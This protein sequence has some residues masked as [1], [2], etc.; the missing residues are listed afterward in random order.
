[1]S[2]QKEITFNQ[3]KNEKNGKGFSTALLFNMSPLQNSLFETEGVENPKLNTSAS[4]AQGDTSSMMNDFLTSDL[5]QKIDQLSPITSTRQP[6]SRMSDVEMVNC[7]EENDSPSSEL[8]ESSS[9]ELE[10]KEEFPIEKK[11]KKKKNAKVTFGVS[12]MEKEDKKSE[13]KKLN[14]SYTAREA[15]KENFIENK[16]NNSTIN[17]HNKSFSNANNTSRIF[18][19]YENTSKYLSQALAEEEKN[20]KKLFDSLNNSH[21]YIPKSK[22]DNKDIFK[23][24]YNLAK[25]EQL[26]NEDNQFD[27]SATKFFGALK[28]T[29]TS[30]YSFN[31]FNISNDSSVPTTPQIPT[32]KEQDQQPQFEY[33]NQY[34]NSNNNFNM[35]NQQQNMQNKNYYDFVNQYQMLQQQ[36]QIPN[37]NP[38]EMNNNYFDYMTMLMNNNNPQFNIPS[39]QLPQTQIESSIFPQSNSNKKNKK[40][41][42]KAQKKKSFN[43]NTEEETSTPTQSSNKVLPESAN[44]DKPEE[45][46][47]EMFGRIGW[48]CNQCNNFNYETRN[49]CNRCGVTKSPKKLSEIKKKKERDSSKEKK[50]NKEHKG[51]WICP[52]CSNLNFGFRKVCNRCQI[53]RDEV[54]EQTPS[55]MQFPMQVINNGQIN[56]NYHHNSS[57]N[58]LNYNNE[59]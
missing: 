32:L 20:D 49:K 25:K 41:H 37:R 11:K 1:M 31:K 21:N 10:L 44:V 29:D 42:K 4:A 39:Q 5:M 17:Y 52:Q 19:Y 33:W 18:S 9:E 30:D 45:Y 3:Q 2:K 14:K 59:N 26:P 56:I 43:S 34:S 23:F 58:V 50:K 8:L 47:L 16:A 27:N 57:N 6:K 38:Q 36:N 54:N 7:E 15:K 24:D 46:L 40:S 28:H 51:D 55:T 22:C 12:S 13:I 48:I 35:Y 53:P